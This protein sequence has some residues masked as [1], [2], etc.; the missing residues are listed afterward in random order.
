MPTDREISKIISA[1]RKARDKAEEK[2]KPLHTVTMNYG[3][4]CNVCVKDMVKIAVEDCIR[5]M[6]YARSQMNSKIRPVRQKVSY[7]LIFRV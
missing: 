7:T 5:H 3:C 6:R 4:F 1:Y 2:G